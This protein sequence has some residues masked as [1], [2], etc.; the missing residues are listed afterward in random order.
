MTTQVPSGSAGSGPASGSDDVA[1]TGSV[2]LISVRIRVGSGLMAASDDPFFLRL[3]GSCGRDFRLLQSSGKSLR[4]GRED[5]FVL[6]PP[7]SK[8]TS[9]SHPQ[10]NDPTSPQLYL[11]GIERVALVKGQ[12][13]LPNV[14]GV[15]E[16][17]DR[18]LI[19][20]AEVR[21]HGEDG[22]IARFHRLGPHWLGL[23]CGLMLDLPRATLETPER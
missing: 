8:E 23:V 4:R 12:A 9:V 2:T 11:D 10:L 20:E 19:D 13:P 1:R 17:D 14:R 16:M 18:L 7:A 15:G 6:G 5:T 21:V 3:T 22:P